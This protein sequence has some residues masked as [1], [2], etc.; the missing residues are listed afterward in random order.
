MKKR[1]VTFSL[2]LIPVF[3]LIASNAFSQDSIMSERWS[4]NTAFNIQKGK[5]ESG[6]FQPFRYGISDKIELRADALLVPVLPN[7]GIRVSLGSSGDFHFASEHSLSIPS[8]FLNL[9]SFK[10]A[11]GLISPEYSFDFIT[12]LNNS[13][14][15]SRK[16]GKSSIISAS[17]GIAF[18]LRAG[19]P[20]YQSTIDIPFIYQRMAHWYDGAS[21]RSEVVFK[22]AF[23]K[24]LWY[25]ESVRLFA[26]TRPADNLFIENSGCIM[27]ASRGSLRIRGGYILS[28][29]RYPFGSHW[30]LWPTIDFVFGNVK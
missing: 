29:G 11:G 18:A 23:S 14:I 22:G 28:W 16:L 24:S 3:L 2:H 20:D 8:L 30:Q 19:K 17:A 12:S 5:W 21:L 6:I 7:A 13:I 25:Q 15:V 26:I 4:Y 1:A 27:W 10:G 9:M